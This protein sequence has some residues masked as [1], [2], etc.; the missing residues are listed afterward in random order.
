MKKPRRQRELDD[1]INR[2]ILIA[3]PALREEYTPDCCIAAAAILTRVFAEYGYKAEVLTVAVAVYNQAMVKVLNQG[4]AIPN[5]PNAREMFFSITGAW[6]VGITPGSAAV[7]AK[8]GIDGFGGHL[9]LRVND[10]LIDATIQQVSRPEKKIV[11]PPMLVID[12]ADELVKGGKRAVQVG[13]CVVVYV[14]I[15][16][17][18]YRTAPDWVRR[19]TPFP[20]TVRKI[21]ARVEQS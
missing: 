3:Y 11:L 8:K 1:L 10:Y 4:I 5:E 17:E 9:I 12:K 6:G 20:E 19:S 16:N 13:S 18:T 21:I 14:P 7:S 15:V 2:L